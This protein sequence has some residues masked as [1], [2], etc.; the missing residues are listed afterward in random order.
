MPT[1]YDG[2]L[3]DGVLIA[4]GTNPWIEVDGIPVDW[5]TTTLPRT[6][7]P[8]EEGFSVVL[9]GVID[10]MDTPVGIQRC[11]ACSRFDGDLDAALALARLVNGVVKFDAAT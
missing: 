1:T 5:T 3:P 2:H 4:D 10:A 11:D 6:E 7:C 9:P 8:C